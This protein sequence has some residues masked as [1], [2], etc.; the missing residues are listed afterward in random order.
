MNKSHLLKKNNNA[1]A[2]SFPSN[3]TLT[4]LPLPLNITAIFSN[5][6]PF[7]FNNNK[8]RKSFFLKKKINFKLVTQ[9]YFYILII[10][11]VYYYKHFFFFFGKC[12]SL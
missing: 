8:Y 11:K 12:N 4:L 10:F 6:F 5:K 1:I 2:Q 9:S 7:A 3:V